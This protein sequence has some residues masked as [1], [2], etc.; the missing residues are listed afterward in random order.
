[1]TQ[2][3]SPKGRHTI[4]DSRFYFGLRTEATR[5]SLPEAPV[6][7]EG[8]LVDSLHEGKRTGPPTLWYLG[9]VDGPRCRANQVVPATGLVD[10]AITTARKKGIVD[11]AGKP[12]LLPCRGNGFPAIRR[13]LTH[14]RVRYNSS[15]KNLPVSNSLQ[16][17]MPNPQGFLQVLADVPE[18][19]GPS[20]SSDCFVPHLT[21]ILQRVYVYFS[22]RSRSWHAKCPRSCESV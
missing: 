8:F 6:R 14:G 20:G 13:R 1:M 17:L 12:D 9:N 16:D 5:V 15:C 2:L 3:G 4:L 11:Q 21:R 22:R 19:S 10:D 18:R 7:G